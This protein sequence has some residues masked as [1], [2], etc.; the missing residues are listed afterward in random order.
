MTEVPSQVLRMVYRKRPRLFS[1][2]CTTN[3][4]EKETF[5]KVGESSIF[6][7]PSGQTTQSLTHST[8]SH[9]QKIIHTSKDS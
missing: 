9:E 5:G 3:E 1:K 4:S 7:Q 8:T 2:S 6:T